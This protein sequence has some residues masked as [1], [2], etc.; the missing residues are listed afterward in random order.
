MKIN[1]SLKF[2]HLDPALPACV[3]EAKLEMLDVSRHFLVGPLEGCDSSVPPVAAQ[4]LPAFH[5]PSS[6][7]T[8][9]S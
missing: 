3:A 6:T 1:Q 9:G 2:H 5:V 8:Y 4:D 7:S